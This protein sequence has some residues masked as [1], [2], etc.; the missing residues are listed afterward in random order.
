M[1]FRDQI[2]RINNCGRAMLGMSA[3][4][5]DMQ[6]GVCLGYYNLGTSALEA[7]CSFVERWTISSVFNA[8]ESAEVRVE[9]GLATIA[10]TA[11]GLAI[12]IVLHHRSCAHVTACC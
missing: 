9:A 4:H 11:I 1:A 10:V 5:T 8:G 7:V 2:G 12:F 6:L 3:T